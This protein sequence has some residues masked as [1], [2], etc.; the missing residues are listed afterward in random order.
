[1]SRFIGE[2]GPLIGLV[3][4]LDEGEEWIIGRDPDKADMILED[5]TVSRKQA[6]CFRT[7]TGLFIKNL[8][9]VNPTEVNGSEL[10]E[11]PVLLNEGDHIKIGNTIFSY[12]EKENPNEEKKPKRRK[13]AAPK[14]EKEKETKKGF[15]DIFGDIGGGDEPAIFKGTEPEPEPESEPEEKTEPEAE[16]EEETPPPVEEE[17]PKKEEKKRKKAP[18]KKAA[19]ERSVYDTIFEDTIDEEELPFNFISE[20]PLILKVIAGPNAGAEIGIEKNTTYVIGKDPNSCDVV[21][22]D[23][24]VS[25]NHARLNID[26]EGNA[27]IE[28]LKSKNGTMINGSPIKEKTKVTQQDL[29]AL[30]TTT[31]LIIDRTAAQ[32]TIYSPAPAAYEVKEEEEAEEELDE[33]AAK[34]KLKKHW[35]KQVIPTPYL[36]AAGAFVVVVFVIAMS[37]FSLFKSS[38]IEVAVR[39]PESR[40]ENAL[41]KFK[42][43]EFSYNPGSGKLFLVGH[44]LTGVDYQ[45]M[46]FR[47]SELPFVQSTEDN[48]VIDELV[49]KMMNDVLTENAGWKGV[50]IHSPKAGQ[51]VV[52]GYIQNEQQMTQLQEYLVVNFPYMD[53]LQNRV[54]VESNLNSKIQSMLLGAGFSGVTFQLAN[55]TVVLQGRYGEEHQKAFSNILDELNKTNGVRSVHNFAIASTESA[56]RIDL[57][58]K[59]KVTGYSLHDSMSFSVVV[60]GKI[61]TK[62]EIL[63]GM[64]ISAIEPNMI[65]LE[66]DGLKYKIDYSR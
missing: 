46:M 11:D 10:G 26:A 27:E 14:E 8:S 36:A 29:V 64:M 2:E 58:Q 1:M 23:L 43:V 53:R 65:L 20:A 54:V 60:N 21:F 5:S 7:D 59:Y 31:F 41:D 56:A 3:L 47:I 16:L 44:V 18:R 48:V 30:G 12:T 52:N 57:T 17:K 45:E 61:V 37:F 63:D 25:R 51:F 33:A 6:L 4:H 42:D 50:S 28:D 62:G 19:E 66:K 24:S 13:K 49:W 38:R 32:E 9:D 15:D 55:G 35:K 40:L 22:Q 34:V 39:H